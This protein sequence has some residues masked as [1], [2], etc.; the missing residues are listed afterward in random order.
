MP[1]FF[2]SSPI[3]GKSELTMCK[4]PLLGDPLLQVLERLHN[5]RK[6]CSMVQLKGTS[7]AGAHQIGG[8][9]SLA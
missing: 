5:L 9:F 4:D 8:L 7:A 6:H 3:R 1:I 2:A